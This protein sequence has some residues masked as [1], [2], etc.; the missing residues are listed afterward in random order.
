[1]SDDPF[2]L[3]TFNQGDEPPKPK[4][5]PASAPDGT[6]MPVP[7]PGTASEPGSAPESGEARDSA[8]ISVTIAE[9]DARP[10]ATW[11][12]PDDEPE[13]VE[14]PATSVSA[15][16]TSEAEG[17]FGAYLQL[18]AD[19]RDLSRS[20]AASALEMILDGTACDTEAAA[21]L[22]GLRVKGET[23]DEIA[24]LLEIMHRMVIPVETV[25]R[26]ALV[27][28]VG[29]GGDQLGT[30][31]ISTTA[32][33]VAAGA[34]AKVAKHGSRAASSKC[35]SADVLEA[36]G[37]RTDLTPEEVAT[38]IEQVGM[39]FMLATRHH[40]IMGKVAPIRSALGLRTVFNFL[41]PLTNPA[42]V[43][44]LLLG[45]S[46]SEHLEVLA[47]AL[48]RVGCTHALLVRSDEGM[49]ELSVASPT[50][51]VEV[52]RGVVQSPY[53]LAPE[54]CGVQRWAL[55]GLVG[56]DAAANAFIVQG[57]MSGSKGAPRDA[58][59]LNAGA[60]LYVAGLVSSIREGVEAA[61]AA[62]DD[63]RAAKVLE[64]LAALTTRLAEARA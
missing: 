2:G 24:G 63:G 44:R 28:I 51:V 26:N 11:A 9:V 47:G 60:A 19:R 45:V 32:A 40:P 41:G 37:I 43:Q 23:S 6:Q 53:S 61:E 5:D 13:P 1:M 30:F 31:N 10:Q 4:A 18:I 15:S 25:D 59:V 29:T 35:G 50:T 16:G 34:G 36:L 46:S 48:A 33:F 22:M 38:C 52:E 57:V 64:A 27:D 21:F 55:R 62:I 3:A 39:G 12:V 49:D 56:G 14:R 42:G 17:T 7:E 58:A 8:M 20:E 54:E